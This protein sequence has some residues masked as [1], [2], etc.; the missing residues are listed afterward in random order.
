M[1]FSSDREEQGETLPPSLSA[2]PVSFSREEWI[3]TGIC[4]RDFFA[5]PQ[6]GSLAEISNRLQDLC[7]RHP[8]LPAIPSSG[9]WLEV[10][11]DFNRLF[12]GPMALLAPPYASVYLYTEPQVMGK[13]T[14]EIRKCYHEL[15]FEVSLENQFPD[16][17][18]SYEIEAC[19][20]LVS[21]P[22]LTPEQRE[23]LNWLT[24]Q[25]LSKW[26]P[27]FITRIKAHVSTP[28]I[29]SVADVLSLWFFDLQRRILH[30]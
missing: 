23:V 29:A 12:V 2:L 7:L 19:L 11:Y 28:L 22:E 24:H 17:S 14:L 9:D 21:L 16:D 26:L 1:F 5:F 20:L 6:S 3:A 13:S 18:I 25:H 8:G 15:G 4:L 10:E 27:D 30:D